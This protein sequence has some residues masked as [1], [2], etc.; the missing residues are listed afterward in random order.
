MFSYIQN[1]C[2]SVAVRSLDWRGT[3]IPTTHENSALNQSVTE[4][5]RCGKCCAMDKNIGCLWCHEVEAVKYF[6]LLDMIY[7]DKNAVTPRWFKAAN[8]IV[9]F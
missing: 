7:R 6:E 2:L 5:H 4:W 8:E 1:A 3:V 9:Y